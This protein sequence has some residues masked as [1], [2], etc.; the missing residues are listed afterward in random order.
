MLSHNSLG[1][2]G[3]TMKYRPWMILFTEQYRDKKDAI[4]REK[5]LNQS[6]GILFTDQF[7]GFYYDVVAP[8][9]F[10]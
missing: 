10:S 3:Y 2:K 8:K 6:P 9:G 7:D 5:K 1:K 4:K